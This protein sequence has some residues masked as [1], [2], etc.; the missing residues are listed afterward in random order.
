MSRKRS[1]YESDESN[2]ESD[3]ESGYESGHEENDENLKDDKLRRI[4][5]S[6]IESSFFRKRKQDEELLDT[7]SNMSIEDDSQ[8][9]KKT[10]SNITQPIK[11]HLRAK[12]VDYYD[13]LFKK[14]GGKKSKKRYK[15]IKKKYKKRTKTRKRKNIKNKK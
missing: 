2:E 6:E 7:L 10:L 1:I 3:I 14:N 5:P 12:R 15:T 4:E 13:N 9:N 8:S 11:Q